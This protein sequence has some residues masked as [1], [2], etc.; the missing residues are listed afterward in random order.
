M[1]L[2]EETHILEC[3]LGKLG[4]S[5]LSTCLSSARSQSGHAHGNGKNTK[6]HVETLKAS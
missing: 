2:A 6:E 3:L 1:V 4:H 5:S